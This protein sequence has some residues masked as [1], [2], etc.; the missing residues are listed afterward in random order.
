MQW[1]K[2]LSYKG[3]KGQSYEI[4]QAVIILLFS[5]HNSKII[6]FNFSNNIFSFLKEMAHAIILKRSFFLTQFSLLV[7]YYYTKNN[8]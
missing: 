6:L 1:G 4:H 5:I 7:D 3:V 2:P 8:N